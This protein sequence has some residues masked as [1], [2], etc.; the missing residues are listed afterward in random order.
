MTRSVRWGPR[1]GQCAR[2]KCARRSHGRAA[3]GQSWGRSTPAERGGRCLLVVRRLVRGRAVLR[4]HQPRRAELV[5]RLVRV[6][7]ERGH[8][9]HVGAACD[10]RIQ[11]LT[12]MPWESPP[13][14]APAG[15]W[16]SA[17][18][19]PAATCRPWHTGTSTWSTHG[20]LRPL[21]SGRRRMPD[22]CE[23]SRMR[24]LSVNTASARW[25]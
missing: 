24:P 4:R 23:A 6:L 2:H 20:L 17:A 14:P 5:P 19:P 21:G 11:R 7:V 9:R 15:K 12:P 22:S 13:R 8:P 3:V 10:R 25:V 1:H 18:P 16:R